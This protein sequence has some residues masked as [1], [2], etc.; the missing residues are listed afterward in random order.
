[1]MNKIDIFIEQ[2]DDLFF[3]VKIGVYAAGFKR[4]NGPVLIEQSPFGII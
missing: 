3:I 1:V 2:L 4:S